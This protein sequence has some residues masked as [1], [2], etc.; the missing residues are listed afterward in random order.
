MHIDKNRLLPIAQSAH[1][2]VYAGGTG[3]R[4]AARFSNATVALIILMPLTF[5]GVFLGQ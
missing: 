5:T 1:R 2:L 3:V 4:V